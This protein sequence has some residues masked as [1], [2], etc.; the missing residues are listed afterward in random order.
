MIKIHLHAN[1]ESTKRVKNTLAADAR[2]TNE[3]A[4]GLDANGAMTKEFETALAADARKTNE[5][6]NGR[7]AGDKMTNGIDPIA[8]NIATDVCKNG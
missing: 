4:Y 5:F 7:G 1:A 2:K 3:F 8:Y 6:V